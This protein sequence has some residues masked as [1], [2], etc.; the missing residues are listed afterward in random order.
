MF[1]FETEQKIHEI[2]SIRLGGQ[3]GQLPTVM[4]GS[5]FHRGHGIVSDHGRG[6]FDEKKARHLIQQQ[7]TLSEQIGIPCIVDVFGETPAALEK[8]VEFVSEVT[9]SPFL[10]NAPT[11][12]ARIQGTQSARE[13]GLLD[14]TIYNSINYTLNEQEIEGIKETGVKSALIQ[15]MNP[16]NTRLGGMK[17]IIK[18]DTEAGLLTDSVRAGIEKPL[19]L[20]PVYDVPSMGLGVKGVHLL[21]SEFGLPTGIPPIGIIGTWDRIKGL[22]KDVKKACR[23]SALALSQYSGSDF[24][25]YGSIARAPDL[26]PACAMVD[27]IVAY[28]TRQAYGT[29]ILTEKHPFHKVLG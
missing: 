13:I 4:I 20:A 12:E 10:L 11:A 2:G 29:K 28:I 15:S 21:K 7:D 1:E 23:A 17:E 26:F 19:L 5:I 16:R 18:K 25:I 8:Y 14:R 9:D 27:I 3:P 6:N 22:G 24:I